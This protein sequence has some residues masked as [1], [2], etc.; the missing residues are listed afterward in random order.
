[1]ESL[2]GNQMCLVSSSLWI[3]SV[4]A[5]DYPYSIGCPDELLIEMKK[6]H[7]QQDDALESRAEIIAKE[8]VG[9]DRVIARLEK[10]TNISKQLP[11]HPSCGEIDLIVIIEKA[12]IILV[13][14][15]KNVNKRVRPYDIKLELQ[16]FFE[17]GKCYA[18]KLTKKQEFVAE[19]ID[20]FLEY[21][22]I[23]DK[24]GWKTK[25]SFIVNHLYSSAFMGTEIEFVLA[26][27]FKEYLQ[28]LVV[29]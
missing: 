24:L 1:M 13:A 7:K 18:K 10:F 20:I 3:N 6:I 29:C 17:G 9:E 4:L 14:D 2:Y 22:G 5:G 12:K 25:A 19:N 28:K 15:A 23:V 27:E 16:T 11:K 26:D 21:F 8:V